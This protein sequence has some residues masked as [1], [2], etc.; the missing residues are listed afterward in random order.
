[1]IDIW[2]T[3]PDRQLHHSTSHCKNIDKPTGTK[4]D[5][6]VQ[7]ALSLAHGISLLL[8][9]ELHPIGFAFILQKQKK[10]MLSAI[11]YSQK[12]SFQNVSPLLSFP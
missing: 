1:V 2:S 7:I 9:T 5:K 12:T 3:G 4:I 6:K 11:Q 8:L 10:N